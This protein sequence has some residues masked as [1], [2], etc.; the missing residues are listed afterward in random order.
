MQ[1]A[2]DAHAQLA[3]KLLESRTTLLP[4]IYRRDVSKH[5]HLMHKNSVR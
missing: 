2:K 4:R 3:T 5:C 1:T